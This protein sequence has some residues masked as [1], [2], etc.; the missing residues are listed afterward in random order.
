MKIRLMMIA[1]LSLI[2]LTGLQAGKGHVP[3]AFADK[4]VGARALSL[5][6]AYTLLAD[7]PLALIWNPSTLQLQNG[8]RNLLVEH[9][10]MVGL[11]DYS[12]IGFSS[13]IHSRYS[14]GIGFLHSGDEIMAE[15]IGYLA[16][17][18]DGSN[19]NK[20]TGVETFPAEVVQ[21]GFAMKYYY[22]A[23]GQDAG[24]DLFD[25]LGNHRVS[26]SANGVSVD[27]GSHI[28]VTP[29]DFVGISLKNMF[30]YI[31]WD[32]DNEA[33]TAL[34][35]Y[36]ERIPF[37]LTLGYARIHERWRVAIDI[38][39]SLVA[40][41]EDILCLGGE[42]DL[43]NDFSVRAGY[44]QDLVTADNSKLMAGLGFWLKPPNL[45]TTNISF[46]Y[47]VHYQWQNNNSIMAS[48]SMP[49]GD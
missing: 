48:I 29:N 17:A 11:Y 25:H 16:L 24:Y 23:F 38:N 34:G 36:S 6:G 12:F 18:T 13:N 7:D 10:Q 33:G 21:L 14:I 19:I 22:T 30:S 43:T 28:T 42:Y 1:L 35:S 37:E 9:A 32:S 47:I 5:G 8:D 26:G 44:S 41:T 15:S 45:P 39:T 4:L 3:A 49:F 46:S 2:V 31:K 40:D 27:A 20:I